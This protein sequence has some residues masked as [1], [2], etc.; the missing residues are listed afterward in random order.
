MIGLPK[1]PHTFTQIASP[2][3]LYMPDNQTKVRISGFRDL[4]RYNH[5]ARRSIFQVGGSYAET[6]QPRRIASAYCTQY[7]TNADFLSKANTRPACVIWSSHM[8]RAVMMTV[9]VLLSGPRRPG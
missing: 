6:R 3:V 7:Q 5:V 9:P 1:P 2:Y 4:A 8:R